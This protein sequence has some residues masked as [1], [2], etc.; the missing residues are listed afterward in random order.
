MRNGWEWGGGGS[1]PKSRQLGRRKVISRVN[2]RLP[3]YIAAE[4]EKTRA[5]QAS[6]HGRPRAGRG[7]TGTDSRQGAEGLRL[8]A[9]GRE[10]DRACEPRHTGRSRRRHDTRAVCVCVCLEMKFWDVGRANARPA[11]SVT[12]DRSRS[13]RC[14]L[15]AR[16]VLGVE[17]LSPSTADRGPAQAP[18][19]VHWN[20]GSRPPGRR[21]SLKFSGRP[22]ADCAGGLRAGDSTAHFRAPATR[23]ERGG[24]REAIRRERVGGVW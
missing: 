15:A 2:W 10:E 1:G 23:R 8:L 5:N 13:P 3:P 11:R 18:L 24:R 17:A 21:P 22:D 12:A 16:S 14:R 7:A 6:E 19:A 4:R 20:G 9:E